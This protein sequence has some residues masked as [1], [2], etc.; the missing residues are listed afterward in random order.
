MS[1]T[2]TEAACIAA[3]MASL[4]SAAADMTFVEL[5]LRLLETHQRKMNDGFARIEAIL[6]NKS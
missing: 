2:R 1:G 4:A 6:E 3:S 5:Q